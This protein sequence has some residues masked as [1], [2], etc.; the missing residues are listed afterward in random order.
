MINTFESC[1]ILLMF[2]QANNVIFKPCVAH[3][4]YDNGV[5]IQVPALMLLDY[6]IWVKPSSSFHQN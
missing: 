2:K 3:G 5:F 1:F 4:V 6:N